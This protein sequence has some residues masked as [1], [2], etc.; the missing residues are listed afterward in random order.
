M[1]RC[2]RSRPKCAWAAARV[3]PSSGCAG[4]S[5]AASC[6]SS[7]ACPLD[8]RARGVRARR[9]QAADRHPLR[10]APGRGSRLMK[11]ADVRAKTDDE[12]TEQ[13]RHSRQGDL[14]PALPAR[15][16]PAR[17]HR[18]GSPGA[19]RHRSHQNHSRRAAPPGVSRG[20]SNVETRSAGGRC[21][22]RL[23][24]DGDRAGRAAGHAPGLQE[25]RYALEEICCARRGQQLPHR[26]RGSDRGKPAD[27]EAQALGRVRRSRRMR[28]PD[29]RA[30]DA[31]AGTALPAEQL[32]AEAARRGGAPHD[33]DADAIS[34]SPTIPARAGCSASRCWAARSARPRRSAT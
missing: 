32:A 2:R 34:T 18:A 22:R 28:L 26:R 23:R 3:R 27:L 14:Q 6:S 17:E 8:D 9:R 30:A 31:A 10:D 11:A 13:A 16:R 24:Q 19:A 15:Q 12:L 21:Q 7:T 33:P 25:V 4:S 5:P 20:R 1:C 29:R